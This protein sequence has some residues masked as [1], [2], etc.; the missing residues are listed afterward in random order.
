METQ[1]RNRPEAPGPLALVQAFVNS[2]NVEF[3]P[4]EFASGEAYAAWLARHGFTPDAAEDTDSGRHDALALR[5]ALRGLLRE[6]NGGEPDEEVR[7]AFDRIAARYP[8]VLRLRD[9]TA[10][11]ALEAAGSDGTPGMLGAVLAIVSETSV[12]GSFPRLKACLDRRCEWAFFDQSRNRSSRWCSMAG[13][14]TRSKMA[15]YRQGRRS[16]AARAQG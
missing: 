14:G 2:V 16:S 10:R 12:D 15:V 4:D 13:C 8:L 6:H 9:G 5:E 3:G 7:A 11:P 1:P